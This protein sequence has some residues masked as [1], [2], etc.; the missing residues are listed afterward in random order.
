MAPVWTA[1]LGLFLAGAAFLAIGIFWSTVFESQVVAALVTFGNLLLFW[2][3]G[4]ADSGDSSF[5][6]D[7]ARN[8]SAVL[9]LVART[10]RV[11]V[12]AR[13]V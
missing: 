3:V 4:M 13:P 10:I 6:S 7:L 11:G 5:L 1:Y 12:R 9:H 2:L 8:A